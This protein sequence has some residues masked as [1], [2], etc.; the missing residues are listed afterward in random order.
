MSTA[1]A[2]YA[3]VQ[4]QTVTLTGTSVRFYAS[5]LV[6]DANGGAYL[7]DGVVHV[8]AA[9]ITVDLRAKRYLAIGDVTVSSA[10]A[11]PAS[12]GSGT[13]VE[14]A[15]GDVFGDELNT[16]H[17]LLVSLDEPPR[18]RVVSGG[19]IGGEPT[20][21]SAAAEPLPVPDFGDETP[22][23]TAHRAVAHVGTDVRLTNVR[24]ALPGARSLPLPSYVYTYS[25]DPGYAISNLA[26]ASEDVPVY[27]GSTRDSVQ[28]LHFIYRPDVKFALG[29]DDRIVDTTHAYVI[30]S[31]APIFGNEKT[32]NFSWQD[33]I[34]SHTQQSLTSES[35]QGIGTINSYDVRDGVH[36]SFI[37]LNGSQYH[38]NFGALLAWQGYDQALAQQG[39]LSDL[40]FHLRSEAGETH[41]PPTFGYSPFP[42]DIFLPQWYSHLA[43]EGYLA[44]K[45]LAVGPATTLTMSGDDRFS[46]DTLPHLQNFQT[47]ALNL[48]QRMNRFVTLT[49]GI[50]DQPIRD[51]F[52]TLD[53]SYAS[54]FTT[55]NASL[56]Y[57]HNNEFA[58]LLTGSHATG[59]T[60]LP[61][62]V[63][64]TPWV[65]GADVR[66]RVYQ[67]LTV[68]LGRSYYFGF[69][70]QRFGTITFQLFP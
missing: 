45:P 65:V 56:Q 52:P 29:F 22:F 3:D 55:E 12:A 62:G 57:N 66:F 28:G 11:L 7:D 70:G 60:Q 47:Y 16:H 69:E 64:V 67:G 23:A 25:S 21:P 63:V 44:T 41:T 54:H 48:T 39:T 33:R 34:N 58:M 24:V 2:A 51:D 5:H 46:H 15:Q 35:I 10:H 31:I 13:V 37:E 4:G 18:R 30:A 68:E 19:E 32:L 36:R 61:A 42:S 6:L 50:I 53:A 59:S 17:G 1:T 9:H 26:G 14:S 49:G 40:V 38:Q 8:S 43:F 20:G 27:F